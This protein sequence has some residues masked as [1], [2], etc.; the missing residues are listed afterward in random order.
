MDVTQPLKQDIKLNLDGEV[1]SQKVEYPNNIPKFCN[2]CLMLGHHWDNCKWNKE[3]V[4]YKDNAMRNNPIPHH[5]EW[6]KVKRRN[7]RID[8]QV[9]NQSQNAGS[10]GRNTQVQNLDRQVEKVN[11]NMPNQIQTQSIVEGNQKS[12]TP[13]TDTQKRVTSNNQNK[14]SN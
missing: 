7:P 12:N 6:T 2:K 3:S 4:N 13:P 14:G 8:Q 10:D 5:P 1:V 9:Q 11:Q